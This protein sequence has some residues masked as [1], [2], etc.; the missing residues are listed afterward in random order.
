M[1]TAAL[2]STTEPALPRR[3]HHCNKHRPLGCANAEGSTRRDKHIG[4][5]SLSFKGLATHSERML[6]LEWVALQ[7]ALGTKASTSTSLS[8]IT[9]WCRMQG[10]TVY[11]VIYCWLGILVGNRVNV[12]LTRSTI[13]SFTPI[14]IF[15]YRSKNRPHGGE[16][17]WK[18]LGILRFTQDGG[19]YRHPGWQLL[20]NT[21]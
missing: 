3:S 21:Q 16:P 5:A 12:G 19:S 8:N 2:I 1:K 11:R 4:R 6:A 15:Q 7:S 17:L 18:G 13:S 10:G 20:K 14:S 9:H